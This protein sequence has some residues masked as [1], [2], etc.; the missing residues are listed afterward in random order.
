MFDDFELSPRSGRP[1]Q[2]FVFM[3]QNKSWLF[4]S[5]DR[6]VT[7][8]ANTYLA[9][10]ISRSEIKQ[11]KNAQ[12]DQITIT[13]AFTR[14]PNA[15]E[16]PVTQDLGNTWFPYVPHDRVQVFCY[17]YHADDPDQ[18]MVMRWQG[19]VAQ[20]SFN[21]KKSELTLTCVRKNASD[22]NRRRG[23]KW[24]KTCWKTTYST[25]LRGCLLDPAAYLIDATVTGVNGL[26]ITAAEFATSQFSLFG[27]TFSWTRADGIVEERPIMAHT[28]G[29]NQV[30]LL[31][32]GADL[33]NGLAVTAL[34]ICPGTWAACDARGNT[35][36]Y[37]GSLYE[38][39]QSPYDGESMSWG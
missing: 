16:L 27:G 18:Q 17:D 24:Q 11:T 14:N 37:G 38:P 15:T 1:R 25:G 28:V 21:D 13:L 30:T 32:G 35:I 20:P 31:Y 34:P 6:N 12:Q 36:H 5:G 4:T 33:A 26:V 7:I 39:I 29:S 8:A 2:L 10:Q 3:R 22:K 9:A 23:P 19:K